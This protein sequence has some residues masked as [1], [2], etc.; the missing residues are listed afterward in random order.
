M[1]KPYQLTEAAAVLDV[2]KRW[3]IGRRDARAFLVAVG[4]L[5]DGRTAS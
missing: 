5:S 2:A 1:A 4:Y 3:R